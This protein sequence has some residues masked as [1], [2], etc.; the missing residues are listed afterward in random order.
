M[1]HHKAKRKCKKHLEQADQTKKAQNKPHLIDN[2]GKTEI[3]PPTLV[4]NTS[5]LVIFTNNIVYG[6]ISYILHCI[7]SRNIL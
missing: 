2:L 3:P 4:G 1:F 7:L 5:H 6:D